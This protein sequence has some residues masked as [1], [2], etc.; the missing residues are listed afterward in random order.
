MKNVKS[1]G[2]FWDARNELAV[3]TKKRCESVLRKCG[4]RFGDAGK[5]GKYG[6]VIVVGGD[7]TML[8]A[9]REFDAPLLG[10]NCGKVGHIMEI[11]CSE[12]GLLKDVI[13]GKYSLEKRQRISCRIDGKDAG[14]ALNEALVAAKDPISLV[15]YRLEA[16]GK[17]KW[18]DSGDGVMVCTPTGSTGH[19]LSAGGAEISKGAKVVQVVPLNSAS[20][21]RRPLV[22]EESAEIRICGIHSRKGSIVIMDGQ[23][24]GIVE[25]EVV[26][27]K[28]RPVS[29]V[30]LKRLKTALGRGK[31]SAAGKAILACLAEGPLNQ[32]EI[33]G[34]SGLSERTV[35]RVLERLLKEG[36]ISKKRG[37]QDRRKAV[38]TARAVL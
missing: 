36:H 19:A 4:I 17:P 11:D 20:L 1:I 5:G 21:G 22:L 15:S 29:L 31:V 37:E 33:T 27:R 38:F 13:K 16:N 30:V 23:N 9:A 14:Y 18:A 7:G 2:I 25:K 12:T 34:K 32:K 24:T 26:I 3:A 28:G 10:I 6:I 8:K 35:R